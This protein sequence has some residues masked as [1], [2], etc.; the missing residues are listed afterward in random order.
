MRDWLH[1]EDHVTAL[2]RVLTRGRLGERYNIGGDAEWANIDVVRLICEL[3]DARRPRAD[4]A[5]Y[6]DQITFVTDRKGHDL[7]Y[8]ID[9]AK[10]RAEL[11]W[12]PS[13]D[14]QSGLA[15]TVDWYLANPA[16]WGGPA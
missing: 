4:G 6:A 16:W 1:V 15:A 13:H 9:P 5:S 11:D 2:E 8:A 14:F 10:V 3:L 7:R 12:R